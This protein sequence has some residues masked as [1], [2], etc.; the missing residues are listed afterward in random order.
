MGTP[1]TNTTNPHLSNT[2]RSLVEWLA[3]Q[4]IPYVIIG[5]VAVS[6]LAKPRFTQDVAVAVSFDLDRLE[7]L[8]ASA[9][10]CGIAPRRPDAL[11]FARRNRVLLCGMNLRASVWTSPS[12]PCPSSKT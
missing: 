9:A 11:A 3:G 2:L 4:K 7:E 8:L 12:L 10:A 1:L 6:L 5:G